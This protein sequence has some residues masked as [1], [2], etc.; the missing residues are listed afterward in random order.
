MLSGYKSLMYRAIAMMGSGSVVSCW[1]YSMMSK[2]ISEP[3]RSS[4]FSSVI[5]KPSVRA[6]AKAYR[7]P[8][9]SLS[10]T[11]FR[12]FL[13]AGSISSGTASE[14]FRQIRVTERVP[15]L[16]RSPS[17]CISKLNTARGYC[18]ARPHPDS[19]SPG[20]S[21]AK[22]AGCPAYRVRYLVR[23]LASDSRL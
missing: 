23:F 9:S 11:S 10:R 8:L 17:A 18:V 19:R 21:G 2:R 13:T 22:I 14:S 20:A 12:A 3:M 15:A 7:V 5:E 1:V 6:H 4:F 16:L